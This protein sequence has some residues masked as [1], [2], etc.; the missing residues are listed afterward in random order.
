MKSRFVHNLAYI[1]LILALFTS[2][3]SYS[4]KSGKEESRRPLNKE[5]LAATWKS[6]DAEYIFEKDG[7]S[8]IQ[9]NGKNCPG[10]WVL[11]GNTL[12]VNPKK[13]MYEKG[14]PCSKTKV[15]KVTGISVQTL[16]MIPKGENRELQL[17]KLK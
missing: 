13:L 5:M 6:G 2:T 10:T 7:T 9:S 1:S 15:F 4:Q 11:K 3:R 8:L 16:N 14:D 17:T 12:T